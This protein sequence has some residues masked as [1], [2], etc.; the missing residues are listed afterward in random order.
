IAQAAM[1][2]LGR[3][4]RGPARQIIL[5]EQDNAQTPPRRVSADPAAVDAAADDRQ[6]ERLHWG[7][8]IGTHARA[9][10]SRSVSSANPRAD[11]CDVTQRGAALMTSLNLSTFATPTA[12][13]KN[14]NIGASFGLSPTNTTLSAAASTSRSRTSRRKRALV[15]SLS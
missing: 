11:G 14:P 2:Q 8:S 1:D 3:G 15:V 6:I 10:R 9:S 4:A 5:L 12:C 7:C 13:G